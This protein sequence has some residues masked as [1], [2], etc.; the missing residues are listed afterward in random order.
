[1]DF[2]LI[3][4]AGGRSRRIDE[5]K[6]LKILAG[7]P[8]IN[9]V[10]SRFSNFVDEI[11]V[12][13]KS[14]IQKRA[15]SQVLE[16]DARLLIDLDKGESPLVGALTG[17]KESNAAYAFLTGCDT[18]FISTAAIRLLLE[19]VRGFDAA[20]FQWPNGWIEPLTAAYR[21]EPSMRLAKAYYMQGELRLR[22]VLTSLPRLKILPVSMLQD[23]DPNLLTFFDLD[24]LEDFQKAEKILKGAEVAHFSSRRFSNI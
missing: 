7:E 23:F 5:D 12:V 24:T 15:Y 9:H 13:L 18:P 1:M 8:L 2:S 11:I 4:L 19:N 20:T 22:K 6:G 17:F 21:I 3:I 14:E 10:M 16:N